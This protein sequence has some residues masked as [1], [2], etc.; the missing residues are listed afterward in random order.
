MMF[1]SGSWPKFVMA[2][3]RS[4]HAAGADG[5]DDRD[6]EEDERQAHLEELRALQRLIDDGRGGQCDARRDE[7]ADR[8]QRHVTATY[9]ERK[10]RHTARRPSRPHVRHD[11]EQA[12]QHAPRLPESDESRN[13]RLARGERVALDLHV[14]EVLH[15]DAEHGR[16]EETGADRRGDIRPDD[17]LTG[18]HPQPGEDDARS[19]H[20]AQGQR[21][22]HVPIRHRRQIAVADRI[23]EVRGCCT[24]RCCWLG[25]HGAILARIILEG[26]LNPPSAVSASLNAP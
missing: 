19:E 13:G 15:R 2:C 22:G 21:I 24:G 5:G 4:A 11:R 8:D 6:G 18:A 17:V 23:E 25:A 1:E 14:E 9:Q 7:D 26:P 16:P 10:D 3:G 20:F 12:E